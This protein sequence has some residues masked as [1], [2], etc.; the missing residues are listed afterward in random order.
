[1]EELQPHSYMDGAGMTLSGACLAG[2]GLRA[3]SFYQN[4]YVL[5]SLLLFACTTLP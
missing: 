3:C 4:W 2:L 1:M 5:Q